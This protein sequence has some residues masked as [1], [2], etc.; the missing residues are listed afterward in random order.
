MKAADTVLEE[1]P[2]AMVTEPGAAALKSLD[3]AVPADTV[4]GMVNCRW[5]VT[6]D[7]KDAATVTGWAAAR[8]ATVL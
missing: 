3:P 7:G 6:P 2:E 4:S 1:L 5:A 8:S